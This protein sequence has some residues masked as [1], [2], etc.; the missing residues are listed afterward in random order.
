MSEAANPYLEARREWNERYGSYIAQAATWRMVAVVALL[1]AIVSVGG[2]IYV[3][4]KSQFIPYLVEVDG[5]GRAAAVG[6]LTEANEQNPMVTK[7]MLAGFVRNWREV[8][9]DIEIQKRRIF[10]AYAHISQADPSF[11]TA[12][13][14]FK[15]NDPFERA[16]TETVVVEVE[17]PLSLGNGAWQ[18][19]WV[20]RRRDRKGKTLGKTKRYQAVLHTAHAKASRD[21]KRIQVNPVGLYITEFNWTEMLATAGDAQ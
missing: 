10:A 18:I 6:P 14:Y 7:A 20:E 5:Q 4:G 21:I 13:E 8:T 1:L 17:S 11:T 9:A 12:N 3:A 16:K 2:L 19:E 15:A